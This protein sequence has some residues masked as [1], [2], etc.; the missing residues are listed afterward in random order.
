MHILERLLGSEISQFDIGIFGPNLRPV[1][2]DSVSDR[3]LSTDEMADICASSRLVLNIGRDMN[4]AN[5]R[6]NI[7]PE[8]PGPRTFDVAL[9]GAPQL[10]FNDGV[11]IEHFYDPGKEIILFDNVSDAV[12]SI[13][14]VNKY[15]KEGEKIA[16]ESQKRT[17]NNHLYQHRI[18]DIMKFAGFL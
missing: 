11:L 9:S 3:R 14:R 12:E 10:L 1:L 7:I 2:G 6:F 13:K 15:P 18:A 16:I 4:I 8:T 5:N 17:N